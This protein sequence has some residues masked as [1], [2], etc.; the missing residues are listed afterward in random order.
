MDRANQ[1]A[2]KE[3]HRV[4][5]YVL[6]T[7]EM[8]LKFAPNVEEKGWRMTVYTDSDYAGDQDTRISVTGY[9]LYCVEIKGSKVSDTELK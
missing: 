5:K 7:K 4:I 6:D 1:A 3:L 8:G 2:Y 9:V